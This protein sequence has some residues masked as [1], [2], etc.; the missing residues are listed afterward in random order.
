MLLTL[1]H[2]EVHEI[3]VVI[4]R[5]STVLHSVLRVPHFVLDGVDEGSRRTR[6]LEA[7]FVGRRDD[8][9]V[10]FIAVFGL[11]AHTT[12]TATKHSA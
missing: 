9:V 1:Y 11:S 10:A 5:T 3:N 2:A 7:D 12:H 4:Y 6:A 8:D